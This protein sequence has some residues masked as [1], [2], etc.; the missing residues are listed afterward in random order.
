ME[1]S[2]KELVGEN[3]SVIGIDLLPIRPIHGII[4]LQ[5]NITKN[6]SIDQIKSIIED[7][8]VDVILSDMSP[9]ISGNYSIDHARS[10]YLC[11]QAYNSVESLLRDGGNFVCKIFSG[12]DLDNFMQKTNQRFQ[13]VKRF[14]PVA[15]RK[16]SSEIYIIAKSFQ[17]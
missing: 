17:K 6:E 8:K 9:N 15:T 11:E 16:S 12:E 14:S 4:F 13:M 5:G 3:G 2:S 10:I 1:S 7:K